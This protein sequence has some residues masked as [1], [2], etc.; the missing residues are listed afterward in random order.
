MKA[1]LFAYLIILQL[2]INAQKIGTMTDTRD[3]QEYKTITH[4]IMSKAR[5]ETSVTWMAENLRYKTKD[6]YSREDTSTLNLQFGQLYLWEDAQR[7]C[8]IGWRLPTD[9]DWTI[10]VNLYGGFDSAGKHLKSTSNLWANSGK[11]TNKSLFNAEPYGTGNEKSTYPNFGSHAIF[12]SA[13]EKDEDYAW[14]WILFTRWDK[15]LRSDGHKYTTAN[16]IRCVENK[17]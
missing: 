15:I 9:E 13:T 1:I 17:E 5:N 3:E 4:V 10:L 11:G 7:A 6:S 8:P 14:D 12:W 16:S 2:S